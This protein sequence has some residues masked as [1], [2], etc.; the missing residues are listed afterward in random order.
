MHTSNQEEPSRHTAPDRPPIP[1]H[2]EPAIDQEPSTARLS[3]EEPGSAPPPSGTAKDQEEQGKTTAGSVVHPLAALKPLTAYELSQLDIP[4]PDFLVDGVLP[5]GASLLASKP[6]V[7]KTLLA[8]G[9]SLAISTG[10]DAYGTSGVT[11]GRVLF[12]ALEGDRRGMKRRLARMLDGREAPKN[13]DIVTH[14]PPLPDGGIDLLR[15][16][17]AA[18]PET[19]LI[20]IDTLKR[21]RGR[22]KLGRNQYDEDY[23]ALAPLAE[24]YNDTHT[25]V[26]VIHHLNKRTDGDDL[27]TVSGSTGLTGAV[28]NIL[29]MKKTPASLPDATLHLIPREEEETELAL[30]FDQKRNLWTFEGYADAF[31]STAERQQ[32]VDVLREADGP[33]TP[34]EIAEK[35]GK[36]QGSIRFLLSKMLE[37]G[38][39]ARPERGMYR[40]VASTP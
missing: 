25:S 2:R 19:R 32:I 18:F 29:L 33:M 22:G 40:P 8:M 13:L 34:K 6:K 7:G 31:A 24:F 11:Q 16:Y 20:V 37:K 14:F 10:E 28:D 21:V 17:V 35:L 39:I 23:E 38:E 27:D 36:S 3:D 26:L 30:R 9:I 1:L 15:K 5:E 12:L 4:E